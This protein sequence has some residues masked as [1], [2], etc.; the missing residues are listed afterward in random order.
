[1]QT[2]KQ[3]REGSRG[4]WVFIYFPSDDDIPCKWT[5]DVHRRL[6]TDAMPSL[7]LNG[8]G[9]TADNQGICGAVKRLIGRS[10]RRDPP[11]MYRRRL[12]RE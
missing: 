2:H 6:A 3:V 10:K 1:M 11:T 12:E 9:G 7:L 8:A 4:G 5:Q